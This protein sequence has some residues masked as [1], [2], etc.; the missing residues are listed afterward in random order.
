MTRFEERKKLF[1]DIHVFYMD[2]TELFAAEEAELRQ[3]WAATEA[4]A[5]VQP[6]RSSDSRVRWNGRLGK[7]L[8]RWPRPGGIGHHLGHGRNVR[9]VS[10]YLLVRLQGRRAMML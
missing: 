4:D 1:E 6:G 10:H 2:R 7:R 8:V 3:D 9:Q 5:G